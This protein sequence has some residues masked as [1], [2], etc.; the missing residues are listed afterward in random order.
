MALC[1]TN[2]NGKIQS[3]WN[4]STYTTQHSG[5]GK[6]YLDYS[7]PYTCWHAT[8]VSNTQY[9][10]LGLLLESVLVRRC[11]RH[12]AIWIDINHNHSSISSK[13]PVMRVVQHVSACHIPTLVIHFLY[14]VSLQICNNKNVATF[15]TAMKTMNTLVLSTLFGKVTKKTLYMQSA[16]KHEVLLQQV[17]KKEHERRTYSTWH[18]IYCNVTP[19][20][21]VDGYQHSR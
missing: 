15:I 16:K 19:H 4:N 14:Y 8:C 18:M 6:Y 13:Q 3:A 1:K 12:V 11:W 21:L 9:L 10:L 2:K 20:T 7:C 17:Y 5:N